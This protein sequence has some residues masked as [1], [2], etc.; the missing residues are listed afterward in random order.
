MSH[1]ALEYLRHILDEAN[2]LTLRT[3]RVPVLCG[4]IW[5]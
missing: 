4:S 2:Y 3:S 1:S 5:I